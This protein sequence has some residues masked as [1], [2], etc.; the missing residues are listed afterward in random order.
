MRQELILSLVSKQ[1]PSVLGERSDRHVGPGRNV[2]FQR[3][4]VFGFTLTC[5]I[6][7]Y[8]SSVSIFL[9]EGTNEDATTSHT[10]GRDW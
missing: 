4:G 6:S 7:F 3:T 8:I 9:L 10:P 2:W 5:H 1:P